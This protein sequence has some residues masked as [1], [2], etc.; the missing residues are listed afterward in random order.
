[1]KRGT[2]TFSTRWW[3]H[4][5]QVSYR[6]APGK[7]T[8]DQQESH[9][10]VLPDGHNLESAQPPQ[11]LLAQLHEGWEYQQQN[12]EDTREKRVLGIRLLRISA[13]LLGLDVSLET[14]V[15]CDALKPN[16]PVCVCVCVCVCARLSLGA[17][18]GTEKG[19]HASCVPIHAQMHT[20]VHTCQ[21][22]HVG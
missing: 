8:P 22:M 7:P 21:W 20:W 18:Q 9:Q 6:G 13:R 3:T 19:L 14:W 17:R 1:M 16:K 11:P 2:P 4:K 12:I 15:S 10:R 5:A